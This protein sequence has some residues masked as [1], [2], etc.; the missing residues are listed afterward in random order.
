LSQDDDIKKDCLLQ[1]ALMRRPTMDLLGQSCWNND[2]IIFLK[3]FTA[4]SIGD[5]TK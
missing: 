4:T 2:D 1:P 3:E 5:E